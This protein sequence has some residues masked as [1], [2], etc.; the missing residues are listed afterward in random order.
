M[1]LLRASLCVLL[2]VAGVPLMAQPKPSP[3]EFVA[4]TDVPESE[5]IPAIRLVATAYGFIWVV[6]LGYVW[7]VGKRLR[8]VEV[9][10]D[11]LQRRSK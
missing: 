4:V 2:L 3:D 10:L 7:T 5:Q 6:L 1:R 11:Q 8:T 9:E